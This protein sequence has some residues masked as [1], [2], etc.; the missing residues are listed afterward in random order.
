[1]KNN[2]DTINVEA[3]KTIF[4]VK[5]QKND[6]RYVL[7]GFTPYVVKDQTLRNKLIKNTIAWLDGTVSAENTEEQTTALSIY[8]NPMSDIGY[9]TINGEAENV[10][11]YIIDIYGSRLMTITESEQL[12]SSDILSLNVSELAQGLYYIVGRIGDKSVH[13]PLTVVK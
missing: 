12:S 6:N 8:P 5:V 13:L 2:R 1:M 11:L 7:L 3:E 9:L 10:S 4:G